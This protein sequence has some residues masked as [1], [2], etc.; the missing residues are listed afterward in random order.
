[1]SEYKIQEYK[2]IS[3][4]LE[5][6]VDLVNKNINDGWVPLGGI[7]II[8]IGVEMIG[9]QAMIKRWDVK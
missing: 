9:T 6:T 3:N 1:M 7:Q 4:V 5:N 2:V 8:R